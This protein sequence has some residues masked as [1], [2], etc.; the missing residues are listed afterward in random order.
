M[1][2]VKKNDVIQITPKDKW[3]GC[4]AIVDD[5]KSWGVQCFIQ[6]PFQGRAYYRVAW[7]AFEVI[8]EAAFVPQ[9]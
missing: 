4:L 5:V 6:I 1:K 8:G 3:G 2:N 7:D 9:E